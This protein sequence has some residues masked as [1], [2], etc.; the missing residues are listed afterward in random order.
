MT[1]TEM[2]VLDELKG[3]TNISRSEIA[4][5]VAKTVRTVQRTLDSLREKG[6]IERVGPK[7]NSFWK[8]LK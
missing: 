5:N 4:E 8:I 2:T 7:Q 3:K 6:Y 1:D